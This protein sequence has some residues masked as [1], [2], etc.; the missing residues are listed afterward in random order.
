[1]ML[2]NI[3]QVDLGT[4]G[5]ILQAQSREEILADKLVAFALR[6]RIKNRDLWDIV[7]LVQQ[8]IVLRSE[9]IGAKFSV[10]HKDPSTFAERT[11]SRLDE[12]QSDPKLRE[13]FIREMQRF[14]PVNTVRETVENPDYWTVL[15]QTVREQCRLALRHL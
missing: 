9:W 1:M 2:R 7:W 3:Y 13:A 6:E 10:R 15:I 8:G 5:L 12:M 14:L 11:E 4:S